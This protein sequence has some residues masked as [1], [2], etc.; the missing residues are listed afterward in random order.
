MAIKEDDGGGK[1]MTDKENESEWIALDPTDDTTLI[2]VLSPDFL[3]G[4]GDGFFQTVPKERVEIEESLGV[5]QLFEYYCSLQ[6]ELMGPTE[7]STQRFVPLEGHEEG[8][9]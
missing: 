5:T 3:A 4:G 2:R 1:D 7:M 9:Q 8:Y 6:S